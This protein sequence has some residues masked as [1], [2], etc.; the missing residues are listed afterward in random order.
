M[1]IFLSTNP[2]R[3]RR[4]W[5]EPREIYLLKVDVKSYTAFLHDINCSQCSTKYMMKI[6]SMKWAIEEGQVLMQVQ[7]SSSSKRWF[8]KSYE[9]NSNS[10]PYSHHKAASF[11]LYSY[12]YDFY[13]SK[14]K[15]CMC[16]LCVVIMSLCLRL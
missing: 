5:Q 10:W 6:W 4:E 7:L 8:W 13:L 1:Q 15:G 14:I 16:V 3:W 12:V 2:R 11:I 9:I